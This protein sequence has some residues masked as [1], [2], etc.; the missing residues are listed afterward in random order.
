LTTHSGLVQPEIERRHPVPKRT[1]SPR[2]RGR[3]GASW[4][5]LPIWLRWLASSSTRAS[6]PN[7]P[8]SHPR[9]DRPP[10]CRDSP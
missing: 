5:S 2:D 6:P 4:R 10:Y 7:C 3:R 9:V 1:L 8:C